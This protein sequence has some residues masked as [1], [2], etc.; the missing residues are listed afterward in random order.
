MQTST[1]PS[2]SEPLV[3]VFAFI[4]SAGYNIREILEW[5]SDGTV[6]VIGER[7]V[8]RRQYTLET[9]IQHLQLHIV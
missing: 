1:S 5:R 7:P 9:T 3:E 6:L 4:G 2:P 8:H